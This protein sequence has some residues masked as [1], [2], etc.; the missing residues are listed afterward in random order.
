MSRDYLDNHL[1]SH[2]LDT[3]E[4]SLVFSQTAG[5]SEL[6]EELAVLVMCS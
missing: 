4:N 1:G 2:I 3:L 5:V 6:A